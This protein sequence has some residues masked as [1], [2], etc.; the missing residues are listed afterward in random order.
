M[1][2]L[3]DNEVI[4]RVRLA[5]RWL[6]KFRDADISASNQY[7]DANNSTVGGDSWDDDMGNVFRSEA[8]TPDVIPIGQP[9]YMAINVEVGSAAVSSQTPKLHI[10]A[11]EAREN[12]FPGSPA[13]IQGAWQQT[14]MKQG[15]KRHMRA[16]WQKR[17]ICGMGCVWYRWDEKRGFVI[18]NVTSNRFF[19]D[20]HT[21]DISMKNLDY[22]G[23]AI[24]MPISKAIRTYDPNG[25]NQYF[26]SENREMQAEAKEVSMERAERETKARLNHTDDDGPGASGER[27]TVKIFIYFD[28]ESEV[29]IYQDQ[30]IHRRENLYGAIP[31]LFRKLYEDPRDRILPLGMNVYARGLN[32]QLVWLADIASNTAKNGASISIYDTNVINGET[33]TALQKGSAS[34]YIGIK[35]PLNPAR[36]P[37]VRIPGE[38]LPDGFGVARAEAQAA[39]DGIMGASPGMRGQST[40]GVTATASML[41]ESRSNAM[42]VD[43]QMEYEEWCTD[44]ATAWIA[45]TQKFGGPD[46]K[47]KTPGQAIVLWHAFCAVLSVTVVSGSTSFSNPAT[48]LQASM[49]LFTTIT[50][51]WELF[52]A[53]A[54]KGLIDKVPKIET[55]LNDLLIAFN[56]SNIDEYWEKAPP[57]PQGPA[58]L[59]PDFVKWMQSNYPTAPEDIK[60]QM[61]QMLGFKPSTAPPEQEAPDNSAHIALL[62]AQME[63][64]KLKHKQQEQESDHIH[65]ARMKTLDTASAIAIN[66]AKAAVAPKP[67]ENKPPPSRKKPQT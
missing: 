14:W 42:Q 62:Q 37:I 1:P 52:M 48:E 46:E 17:M 66:N 64:L 63:A 40:P 27:Q 4:G 22:A 38:K 32:Q 61:E 58:T 7:I 24:N 49:Q 2:E 15:M 10:L 26:S 44:V 39:M 55:I 11:N 65:D 51:A 41:S 6:K 54:A 36:P 30:V 3:D 47:K 53:L 59:P 8:D 20:P 19:F 56:R 50:Q 18:D 5:D 33:E 60:R 9:N 23:V 28:M 16:A 25:E 12:G 67:D 31:L 35:S 34:Q 43:N 45:C 29:H 57:P 13:I 21:A